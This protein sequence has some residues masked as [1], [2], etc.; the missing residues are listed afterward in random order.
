MAIYIIEFR[1][2]RRTWLDAFGKLP[3]QTRTQRVMLILI[4]SGILYMLFFV[5]D[6]SACIFELTYPDR[7]VGWNGSTIFQCNY[8]CVL[9]FVTSEFKTPLIDK[10]LDLSLRDV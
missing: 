10:V 1:E 6:G 7:L 8:P 9:F 4:E 3:P 5:R 2:A